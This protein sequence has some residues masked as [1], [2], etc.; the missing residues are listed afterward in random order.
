M[1]YNDWFKISCI[2][3]GTVIGAG[4]ASGQEILQFFG[5][6]GYRGILGIVLATILFAVLSAIVLS[7]VYT[8]KLKSYDELINPIF[9]KLVGN[10]IEIIVTTFLFVGYCVM[11]SGSGAVFNEQFG[12]SY[13]IGIYIM[14]LAAMITFLFNVKGLSVANS[15]IVPLLL[16]GIIITSCS[17]IMK[18]GLILSN[19]HGTKVATTGNWFTSSILY[20]S[21]NSIPVIVILTTLRP[22]LKD[23]KSSI[24]G[25]IVGGLLLGL[26]ASL[27]L[28]SLLIL[29][30]D[31]STLNIPMLK[32]AERIGPLGRISYSVI[33]LL[34]MFTT[35]I[36]NG[37]GFI[38]RVSS[39]SSS[40][41]NYYFTIIIFSIL[42]IP[43][44]KLGFATLVK[45]IYPLFGYLGLLMFLGI[46]FSAFSYKRNR[47]Y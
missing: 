12:L 32:V 31:I 6:F 9:G 2:F 37:F 7:R 1:K 44:A 4:F 10:V 16:I 8:Y 26:I 3:I 45:K 41:I 22:I 47:Y 14:A 11:L 18:D 21:Y 42:T 43:L 27:I 33:L 36:A 34:A 13:D 15:I 39:Y 17:V 5:V 23:K 29:Y 19:L 46:I 24:K 35:A 38:K 30:T 28:I 25:G 40:N 20:V